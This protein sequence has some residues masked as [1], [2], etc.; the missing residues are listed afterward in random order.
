MTNWERSEPI[1]PPKDVSE[2]LYH[3]AQADGVPYDEEL[4][5]FTRELPRRKF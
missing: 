3:E 5:P 1:E 2:G 4:E